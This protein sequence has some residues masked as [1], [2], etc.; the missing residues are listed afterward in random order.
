MDKIIFLDIDGV[1]NNA[2]TSNVVEETGF[3]GL[4]EVNVRVLADLMKK[5]EAEIVISSTWQSDQQMYNYLIN[6]LE[7]Y[8]I[9]I[10]DQTN[11]KGILRGTA[12]RQ[13]V[14]KHNINHYAVIDDWIFPDFLVGNFL[15]HVIKCDEVTGLKEEQI[16][17]IMRV[18]S[19]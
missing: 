15:K 13:Y 7:Q 16:P 18:L 11:E 9:H 12:I 5:V 3:I 19:L 8:D 14:K 10:I 1:L 4:D 17:E 6:N 2:H